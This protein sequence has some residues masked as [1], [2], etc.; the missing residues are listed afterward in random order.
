MCWQAELNFISHRPFLKHS[1]G[2]EIWSPIGR[3]PISV[4]CGAQYLLEYL[5]GDK[6]Q[7]RQSFTYGILV[8]S[9]VKKSGQNESNLCIPIQ[10][11]WSL[12]PSRFEFALPLHYADSSMHPKCVTECR[13]PGHLRVSIWVGFLNFP[14]FS[15]SMCKPTV[16]VLISFGIEQLWTHFSES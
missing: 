3:G 5:G 2:A 9:S 10:F 6:T 1:E 8:C 7:I 14:H 13:Q 4:S 16:L 11:E 15:L 12:H